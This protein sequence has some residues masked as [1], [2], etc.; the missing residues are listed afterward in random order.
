M[1]LKRGNGK[2]LRQSKFLYGYVYDKPSTLLLR[3]FLCD[4]NFSNLFHEHYF[5]TT[6][7][8]KLHRIFASKK[9]LNFD[10]NLWPLTYSCQSPCV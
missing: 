2:F 3:K 6:Y 8:L 10:I 5:C 1:H 7:Y 9:L 4:V